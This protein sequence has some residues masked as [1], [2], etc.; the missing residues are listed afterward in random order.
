MVGLPSNSRMASQFAARGPAWVRKHR[1]YAVLAAQVAAAYE[2]ILPDR[3]L[4]KS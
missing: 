1:T 4:I 2:R 3:P